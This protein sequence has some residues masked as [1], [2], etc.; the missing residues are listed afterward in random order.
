M[1]HARVSGGEVCYNAL[2]MYA[3]KHR[4]GW[5]GDINSNY[6]FNH[7]K[8]SKNYIHLCNQHGRYLNELFIHSFPRKCKCLAVIRN[9]HKSDRQAHEKW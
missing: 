5:I 2:V 8:K 3:E 4:A 1:T 7:P 9:I 6:Y